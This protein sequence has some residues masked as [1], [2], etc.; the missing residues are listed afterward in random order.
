MLLFSEPQARDGN[1]DFYSCTLKKPEKRNFGPSKLWIKSTKKNEPCIIYLFIF[2]LICWTG[3]N[4]AKVFSLRACISRARIYP[5]FIRTPEKAC[6]ATIH[7]KG[8]FFCGVKFKGEF[9]LAFPFSL[10]FYICFSRPSAL[11]EKPNPQVCT[12]DRS[13]TIKIPQSSGRWF[14]LLVVDTEPL[15]DY[16]V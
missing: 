7:L 6:S 14:R 5:S 10:S 2:A 12:N 16:H 1:G 3:P 4:D 9:I 8:S 15:L 13:P 11:E